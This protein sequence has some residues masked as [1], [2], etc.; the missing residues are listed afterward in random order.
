MAK[1]SPTNT[2]STV[3]ALR[4]RCRRD[5][6]FF[7]QE[8]IG[9]AGVATGAYPKNHLLTPARF[10]LD[11]C[12]VVEQE[13]DA[14]LL[15]PRYH[16]KT[17][18]ITVAGTVQFL[19]RN[20][21]HRVL[22]V[23]ETPTL[24]SKVL[25]EIAW[26][27]RKNTRLRTLFPEY[28]MDSIQ[29]EGTKNHFNVPC[30]TGSGKDF[31][32]EAIGV[33]GATAGGHY[34]RIVTTD[35]VSNRT[36]PPEVTDL[37]MEKTFLFVNALEGLRDKTMFKEDGKTKKAHIIIEGTCWSPAD[38]YA[39]VLTDPGYAKFKKVVYSCWAKDES[40]AFILDAEG[41]RT[42]MWPE[43]FT[44]EEFE[45]IRAKNEYLFSC[46]FENDPKPADEDRLFKPSF[47]KNYELTALTEG[48]AYP[49][50]PCCKGPLSVAIT[51]DLAISEA[52]TADF[53]ALIVSGVCPHGSMVVL[54]VA[55]GR[56]TPYETVAQLYDLDRLWKPAW[57]GI[58]SVAWQ[59]AMMFILWEESKKPDRYVLPAR[60]LMPDN[61]PNGKIRRVSALASYAA[62]RGLW[63][64]AGDHD[65]LVD[66]ALRMTRRGSLGG[67]VDEIDSLSY[68]ALNTDAAL[69]VEAEVVPP[70]RALY[71]ASALSGA[72]V[73]DYLEDKSRGAAGSSL[74]LP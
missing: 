26:H 30:K 21:N 2:A 61:S 9:P 17:A 70:P 58:E 15:A 43:V 39:R 62:S 44:R 46:I 28:G 57:I 12:K 60:M 20:P 68:R 34:D 1:V 54:A 69:T 63:V 56:W 50:C 31:S 29:E 4:D 7:V 71:G 47:F 16:L 11:A 23:S 53:T 59:K 18:L 48:V 51:A 55:S 25:W 14:I 65:V 32:V 52:K 24:V 27:F 22:L 36:V 8:I 45:E 6:L 72:E 64:R 37:T 5:L 10:H 49:S 19:L 38:A 74:D 41:R 3:K 40:G 13:V 35:I 33:G 67:K 42:V 73:L 66:Q